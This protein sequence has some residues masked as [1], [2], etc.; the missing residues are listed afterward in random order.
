[1]RKFA[2]ML[3]LSAAI[4]S[5]PTAAQEFDAA[6]VKPSL[7]NPPPLDSLGSL[8]LPPGRWRGLRITLARSRR[9]SA[10]EWPNG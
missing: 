4:A 3:L 7:A 8:R 2:G 5:V 10:S 1:M 6:S 9:R